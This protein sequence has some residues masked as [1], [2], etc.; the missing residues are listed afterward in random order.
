MPECLSSIDAT[1]PAA[2]M[3]HS[4]G[5]APV[6]SRDVAPSGAIGGA[7][8]IAHPNFH[9]SIATPVR[10]RAARAPAVVSSAVMQHQG[11]K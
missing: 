3:R 8:R 10:W 5:H 7:S 11:E 6:P 9:R 2:R 4:N 1:A